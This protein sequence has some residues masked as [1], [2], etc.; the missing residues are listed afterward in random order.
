M[1]RIQLFNFHRVGRNVRTTLI[2]GSKLENVGH[3]A[4]LVEAIIHGM[5]TSTDGMQD[6]E[7]LLSEVLLT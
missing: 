4:G 3:L 2:G 5:H 7:A 1:Q 6:C